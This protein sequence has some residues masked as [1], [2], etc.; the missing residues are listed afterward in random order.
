MLINSKLFT[1]S[2]KCNLST[3]H[4]NGKNKQ[5][6]PLLS[7]EVHKKKRRSYTIRRKIFASW[8]SKWKNGYA[9]EVRG[10]RRIKHWWQHFLSTSQPS[11]TPPL[12]TPQHPIQFLLREYICCYYLHCSQGASTQ[13]GILPIH[14]SCPVFVLSSS[15]LNGKNGIPWKE[16]Y[17][18]YKN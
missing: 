9:D 6:P 4:Q 15:E 14:T 1:N 3:G 18:N 5:H 7:T 11:H 16:T 12:S 13:N 2:P 17:K 8:L 10:I